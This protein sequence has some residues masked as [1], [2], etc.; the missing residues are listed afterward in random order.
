MDNEARQAPRGGV[1]TATESYRHSPEVERKVR[2]RL[3]KEN[4]LPKSV[5]Q[6]TV[7]TPSE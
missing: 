6:M 7:L 4:L 3:V 1:V 2:E 5:L